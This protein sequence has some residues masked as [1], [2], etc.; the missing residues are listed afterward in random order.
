ME[1]SFSIYELCAT[2]RTVF[3]ERNTFA[4]QRVGVSG[5]EITVAECGT[6]VLVF[7]IGQVLHNYD[8]NT[9]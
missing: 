7:L 3:M 2:L 1:I 4:N 9:V 8:R 5:E 6:C